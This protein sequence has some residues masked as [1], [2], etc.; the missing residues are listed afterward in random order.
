MRPVPRL[1]GI[2]LLLGIFVPALAFLPLDGPY[3]LIYDSGC[4]HHLAPHRRISY[5][6]L[7]GRHLAPGGWFGLS[8]FA[9]GEDGMGTE[10]PDAALYRAKTLGRNRSV[11]AGSF[12]EEPA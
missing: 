1:G 12:E 10:R 9:A 3:D 2:A 8:C 4:F 5:L 11:L 6:D 7:L